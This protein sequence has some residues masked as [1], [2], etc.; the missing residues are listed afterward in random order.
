MKLKALF[1][2]L[3]LSLVPIASPAAISPETL[4]TNVVINDSNLSTQEKAESL[5][6][7]AQKLVTPVSSHSRNDRFSLNELPGDSLS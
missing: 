7:M 5:A 3:S 4:D 2:T 1:L 6:K